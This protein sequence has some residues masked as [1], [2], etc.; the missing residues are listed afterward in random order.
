VHV[1][2]HSFAPVLAG[3]VRRADIGL[4]YD[5]RR[6][7]EAGVARTWKAALLASDPR[8]VVRS[9]YPYRGTSDG[10]TKAMRRN[11]G[12]RYAGLEL[13]INQRHAFGASGPWRRLRRVVG[14]TLAQIL[15][16]W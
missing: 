9:N 7:L 4:L 8:R 11:L 12:A 16:D 14:E 1:A 13:E 3:E 6:P 15:H 10:L 2:V 5:P